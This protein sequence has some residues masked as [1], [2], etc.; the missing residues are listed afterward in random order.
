MSEIDKFN[1]CK[2]AAEQGDADAQYRLGM[3]Y[4]DGCGVPQDDEEAAV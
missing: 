2:I 3:M 4:V 1:Q